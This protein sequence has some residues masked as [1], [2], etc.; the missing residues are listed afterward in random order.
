MAKSIPKDIRASLYLDGKPAKKSIRDV[1]QEAVVLRREL[2][3]LTI[4]TDA[5]NAKM[6]QLSIHQRS[7][8]A[9]QAEVRGVGGA[10]SWLK[11]EVGRFGTLAAGYLGFQMITSQ[12][13]NIIAGNAKLSDSLAGIRRV[14]SLTEEEVLRLDQ[15]FGKLDTRTSRTELRGIA[16][17][18]GRMGVAKTEIL[19]FV[20]AVDKLVVSLGEELGNADQIT[21]QLGKILNV[22]DGTVN[23]DNITHLGNAMVKLANDGVASA[24]FIS[25]FTQRLSGMAKTSGMSLGSVLGLGAGLEEMGARVESSATAIQ[26]LLVN[27]GQDIPGSAKV[28]GMSVDE[29]NTLFAKAPQEALIAYAE[30]LTQNKAAFAEVADAFKDAGEEGV[31]VIETLTKIGERADFMREKIADG[32]QSILEATEINEAFG[33]MN[34]TL[35]AK[36]DK[37]TKKFYSMVT[38]KGMMDFFIAIVDGAMSSAQW[39]ERNAVGI[40]NFAK[41]ITTA[42]IAWTA[43][44][45]AT[46]IATSAKMGFMRVLISARTI[47]TL[48]IISTTAL[49]L[50]K[51]VL[52]GN[53]RKARQEWLL[54]NGVMSTNPYGI[55]LAAIAAIGTAL[56]LFS[57]RLTDAQRNVKNLADAQIEAEK[58]TLAERLEIERAQKTI[59]DETKSRLEKLTAVNRLKTIMP[60]VLKNYSD[61]EILAGKATNAIK[62]QTEAIIEQANQRA[63]LNT[64]TR[65]SEEKI[66]L[67][68]QQRR[69]FG[70]ATAG[71]RLST[72]GSVFFKGNYSEAYHDELQKRIEAKEAEIRSIESFIGGSGSKKDDASKLFNNSN[73]FRPNVSRVGDEILHQD[74]VSPFVPKP[75]KDKKTPKEKV[76]PIKKAQEELREWLKK[77]QEDIL[78]DGLL[79]AKKE[80]AVLD[81]KYDK[82]REKAHGNVDLLK[83]IDNQ[84]NDEFIEILNKAGAEAENATNEKNVKLAEAEE[85]LFEAGMTQR[86]KELYDVM[87]HYDQLLMLAEAYGIDSTEIA[88]RYAEA[89]AEIDEKNKKEDKEKADEGK[90]QDMRYAMQMASDL[91]DAIFTIGQDRRRAELDAKLS[92]IERQ[93]EVELSNENL[94]Q[95]QRARINEK[96]EKQIRSEKKKAFQ[97]DKKASIVQAVVNGALAVTKVMAQTGILSPF[98][99]P[100]IVAGTALQ[101]ATIAAQKAPE[102]AV[103]GFSDKDPAGYVSQATL[104]NNSSSGRPFIAGEA[105]KEWIAPNWMVTSPRFANII[106]MLESARQ[107]KRMFSGGGST[108]VSAPAAGGSYDFQR[109]EG[110]M[111]QMLVKLGEAQ[112]KKAYIVYREWEEF[113]EDINNSRK[114]QGRS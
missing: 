79:G 90:E 84:Y 19:G 113:T 75:E 110:L 14:A 7:L 5:W 99:I 114:I 52:T 85:K 49:G 9:I 105:G 27:M 51:A 39:I 72:M 58:A 25:D 73:P 81:Q 44:S 30:G 21:T 97:A 28:A 69:G 33:L 70:G 83:E 96:Y 15:S 10:F 45:L 4:G 86:E 6:K 29:F 20:G 34:E 62:K 32:N 18:A 109:L 55:A 93:R 12:F 87:Q 53:V 64:V 101:V 31:R 60:D 111:G 59:A 23:G 35:G 8:S 56:Y 102:Y 66:D 100:A 103:G 36:V 47:Q 88:K 108:E 17:I 61:E 94:T 104:F 65:L 24:G 11:T 91:S 41:I 38:S 13:Q 46:T 92:S 95:D 40:K 98:A 112:D 78:I 16:M 63:Y 43:Y 1:Q 22:F 54:L 77:N 89:K 107:E 74:D 106:G 26:K 71:E 3:N 68:E 50:A 37:L 2:N 48:D 76:D 57:G 80:V 82:I 67:Q 42:V